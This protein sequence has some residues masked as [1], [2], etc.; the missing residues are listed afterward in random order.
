MHCPYPLFCSSTEEKLQK[1][2][3][4]F[5]WQSRKTVGASLLILLCSGCSTFPFLSPL[6]RSVIKSCPTASLVGCGPTSVYYLLGLI[7]VSFRRCCWRWTLLLLLLDHDL[8]LIRSRRAEVALL[9]GIALR[10]QKKKKK[11]SKKHSH[12]INTELALFA[13]LYQHH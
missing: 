7:V 11:L 8:I 1:V 13:T 9:L 3:L 6:D 4:T 2:H 10:Q 5:F 12:F